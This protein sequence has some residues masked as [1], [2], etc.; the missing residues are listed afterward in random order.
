MTKILFLLATVTFLSACGS[1]SILQS[2]TVSSVVDTEQNQ[3]VQFDSKL[4][5]GALQF[6]ALTLPILNPRNT[7]ELLGKVS[8]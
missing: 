6:P 4:K 5:M 1:N 2:I 7:T 3:W 8:L